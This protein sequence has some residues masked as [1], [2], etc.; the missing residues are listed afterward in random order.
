MTSRSA[1]ELALE[2][3]AAHTSSTPRL[4]ADRP[5]SIAELCRRLS[6]T[7]RTLQQS[8]FVFRLS[9]CYCIFDVIFLPI[10]RIAAQRLQVWADV[11][12]LLGT[13]N[14][15]HGGPRG[16][17]PETCQTTL[18]EDLNLLLDLKEVADT[19][20]YIFSTALQRI[21]ASRWWKNVAQ[22]GFVTRFFQRLGSADYST[23]TQTQKQLFSTLSKYYFPVAGHVLVLS[24]AI[25][26]ASRVLDGGDAS[27]LQDAICLLFSL[28]RDT[29]GSEEDGHPHPLFDRTISDAL[30]RL[31]QR[32]EVE[33]RLRGNKENYL[34]GALFLLYKNQAIP[35]QWKELC[36]TSTISAR[37]VFRTEACSALHVF[38][39]L[40][41]VPGLLLASLD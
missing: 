5:E 21:D 15:K 18:F 1:H 26:V 36:R 28:L 9:V 30:D 32:L 25:W 10:F 34:V 12:D 7:V 38:Q 41:A 35:S 20:P 29:W 17:L 31:R 6:S 3:S 37:Y 11:R 13:L 4:A 23:Y 24:G 8:Q 33:P 14:D 19:E 40:L 27:F 16:G 39:C 22:R 2:F